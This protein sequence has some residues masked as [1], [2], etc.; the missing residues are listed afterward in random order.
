MADGDNAAKVNICVD[1]DDTISVRAFGAVFP[2][3]GVIEGLT[4]LRANGYKIIVHSARAWEK[5]EDR[6]ERIDEMR[7]LLDEWGV[8]Y[9]EIWVGAGKPVAKAYV[10][11]RAIRFDSNWAAIVDSIL[12]LE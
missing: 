5:F 12:N 8:P 10:D 9:N 7:K 3:E 2:A 11:D 6:A 1:F 4:R